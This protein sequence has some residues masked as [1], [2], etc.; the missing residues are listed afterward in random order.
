MAFRIII[1]SNV[2]F[3]VYVIFLRHLKLFSKPEDDVQKILRPEN[4]FKNYRKATYA[5]RIEQRAIIKSCWLRLNTDRN[6]TND[7]DQGNSINIE[8]VRVYFSTRGT[9]NILMEDA[10]VPSNQTVNA[11]YKSTVRIYWYFRVVKLKW[12]KFRNIPPIY[13]SINVIKVLLTLVS[14]CYIIT[15]LLPLACSF[16]HIFFISSSWLFSLQEI[17]L[18]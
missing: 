6:E 18:S 14:N 5:D 1:F 9:N 3:M 4:V 8:I 12:H 11:A 17:T 10:I 2:V 13:R 16:V 7:D 15:I